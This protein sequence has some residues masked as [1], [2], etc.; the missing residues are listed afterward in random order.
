MLEKFFTLLSTNGFSI[1]DYGKWKFKVWVRGMPPWHANIVF[2]IVEE[3]H[4]VIHGAEGE[5]SRF[6]KKPHAGF[7]AKNIIELLRRAKEEE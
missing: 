7:F 2:E 5:Y 6:A 3:G 1:Y 4:V